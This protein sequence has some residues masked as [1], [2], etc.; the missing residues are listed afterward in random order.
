MNRCKLTECLGKPRCARCLS[1]DSPDELTRLRTE[2]ADLRA[3]L[4]QARGALLVCQEHSEWR[5]GSSHSLAI[6]ASAA[7][8][9]IDKVQNAETA[10]ENGR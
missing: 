1:Q 9:A 7:I 5:H 8:A 6:T 4:K 3:T 2:V 10:K